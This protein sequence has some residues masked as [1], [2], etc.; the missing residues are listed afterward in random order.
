MMSCDRN[1]CSFVACNTLQASPWLALASSLHHC[2]QMWVCCR[3]R[4]LV[5]RYMWEISTS[6][7]CLLFYRTQWQWYIARTVVSTEPIDQICFLRRLVAPMGEICS[8]WHHVMIINVHMYLKD[9]CPVD[10]LRACV[11]IYL[12]YI[13]KNNVEFRR[14]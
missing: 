14:K 5:F 7:C 13:L 4:D 11:F 9:E 6:W 8:S 12:P 3:F 2:R 1:I 10:A